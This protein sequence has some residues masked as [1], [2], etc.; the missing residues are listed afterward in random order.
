VLAGPVLAIDIGATTIK[1]AV[2]GPTGEILTTVERTPTP[3]PCPPQAL[4]AVVAELVRR[5]RVSHAG[6]GFPGDYV[7]GVVLEPGNLARAGGITTP[8]DPALDAQWRGF[9]LETALRAATS[10]DVRVVNDATLAALGCA[11]GVGRELVITLGT[12]FG[13]ALIVEGERV[14]VRDVGAEVFEEGLTYDEAIGE[15]ARL[16]DETTWRG[17]LARALA[18]FVGEFAPDVVHLGGGNARLVDATAL[19][20]LG[21]RVALNPNEVALSGAARLFA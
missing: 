20:D 9:A 14:R 2:V 15:H 3:Y 4:V 21:V 7:D 10:C 11:E 19:A 6:V 8:V 12:G 5:S 17:R 16:S 18:G 1:S 13:I